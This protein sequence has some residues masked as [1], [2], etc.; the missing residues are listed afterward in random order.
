MVVLPGF[1]DGHHPG[2]QSWTYKK[3]KSDYGKVVQDLKSD[4]EDDSDDD[5]KPQNDASS[6]SSSTRGGRGT[7][8]SSRI[9]HEAME[10]QKQKLAELERK[11]AAVLERKR[12]KALAEAR[13]RAS[14]G[15]SGAGNE[16]TEEE[17]T[18]EAFKSS[19]EFPRNASSSVPK[20]YPDVDHDCVFF[21]VNGMSVPMHISTI[22]SCTL[23]EERTVAYLRV[24]FTTQA[25]QVPRLQPC[26]S[27]CANRAWRVKS[28]CPK[29]YYRS[30]NARPQKSF[31]IPQQIKDFRSGCAS[32]RRLRILSSRCHCK[33]PNDGSMGRLSNSR[34]S[35]CAP[36][37]GVGAERMACFR[38]I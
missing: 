10:L 19:N 17:K 27:A 34:I 8:R 9:D 5:A 30:A 36:N 7:R 20:I 25:T 3:A 2:A 6:S 24:T 38:C 29:L 32:T 1:S 37:S 18:V 21:P 26:H 15:A 28:L 33:W 31:D 14:M 35:L 22:K 16:L 12:K 11:Q 4:D 23:Q 13:Q